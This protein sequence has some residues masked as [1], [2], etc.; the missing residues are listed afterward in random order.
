[1]QLKAAIIY[2]SRMLKNFNSENYKSSSY[3]KI[4]NDMK[5]YECYNILIGSEYEEVILKIKK[6]FFFLI[7]INFII[8]NLKIFLVLRT[9]IKFVR[10]NRTTKKN[11]IR[12]S[13]ILE[14]KGQIEFLFSYRL[15][16]T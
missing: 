4:L 10:K 2:L 8:Y 6:I 3:Y 13:R 1:M 16:I 5:L 14:I 15:T 12:K 7:L 11:K 9:L